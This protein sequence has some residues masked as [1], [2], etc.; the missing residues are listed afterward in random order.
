MPNIAGV[1]QILPGVTVNVKTLSRGVSVPGG[2]RLAALMGEGSRR[3]D[4]ILTAVGGGDDGL[5]PTFS[6]TTGSDGRHFRLNLSPVISNRTKLYQNGVQLSLTE[7][8]TAFDANFDYDALLDIA[9]GDLTLQAAHLV[10]QGGA[11]Y[12][13]SSSNVGNGTIS[14]LTLLD[15]NA[16]T[17][18]WTIRCA[19][20]RRD[21]YGDPIDGYARFIASGS[22][23]G[24]LLDGYGQQITW[25]SDGVLVDNG[26]LSFAINE[27]ATNFIEGDRFTIKVKS[28]A[29]VKGDRLSAV[30][31]PEIDIND[32][33]FF[34]DFE[35]L[36][37]KHGSVSLDNRLSLGGQL[38]FSNSPP[39]IW[40]V[41]CAPA[42]P[43][44]VS[45]LVEADAPGGS[46]EQANLEFPLP[47]GVVPDSDSNIH[48]FVTDATT[49]VESQIF[50][51]KVA[52]FDATITAN[53]YNF[54]Y[55]DYDYSYT[56]VLEDSV[57]EH[58]ED[59]V[60]TA[61]TSLTATLSS[62]SS[63]FTADDVG[64]DI[65][66][67]NAVDSGNEGTFTITSVDDNV[68]T[69]SRSSGVFTNEASIDF[70]VTDSSSTSA[71]VLIT[72]DL[73]LSAGDQLRLTVVDVKDATFFDA[74]WLGAYEALEAIETDI[75]VP[76]P[77]QTISQIVQNGRVHCETMSNIKNKKERVLLTG[78]IQGLAPENVT[79]VE[80]A[81][82]EDIGILEGIQGDDIAE[83]LAGNTE[84]LTDYSVSNAFGNSFRVIYLYPDEIV[85]QIAGDRVLVDGF[86]M[87]AAVA[88]YLSS[89]PNI[90]IPLTNKV[91]SGFTILRN[92]IYRPITLENL[93]Y[94][95]ITVLQ[96]TSG[97][98]R[99]VWGRTTTQS[100][101]VEEQEISI[102]FIRDRLAKSLRNGFI[103]FI[104]TAESPS[105]QGSLMSRAVGLLNSF[106]SQGLI[107]AYQ[108]LKVVRDTVDP[109]QWNISVSVQPTYPVNFINIEVSIGL[110]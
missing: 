2:V 14:T 15:D 68:L 4:L 7:D 103:G 17:E 9:T 62:V 69:I 106:V 16:P 56:V 36:T 61:L 102:V 18:T 79:G 105:L 34:T 20:V 84:D 40:T 87:A 95:G 99:V 19:S 48:F 110:L 108:D 86:F 91:I 38:A 70:K 92:K 32:V 67:F 85:V 64:R 54:H 78:A 57:Q 33:E 47:L 77:S 35:E 96:P 45:Y 81:A 13:A 89:V 21:G 10:D 24:I 31:I 82:V 53:S 59:G 49:G 39:G 63:T 27:G 26:I 94:A 74:G 55:V 52:F 58:G 12:A 90:A 60:L 44:R 51:N 50:P 93:A 46:A 5:D 6:S 101:F 97:G 37:K 76:L 11:F 29:L 65:T 71:L 100:G 30:Y 28:G 109:T 1:S 3:E 8:E 43:R 80:N 23:S 98:G 83:I 42:V 22:V 75:V 41:E 25:L 73:A 66:L 88:G 72:D 107:T 104:G